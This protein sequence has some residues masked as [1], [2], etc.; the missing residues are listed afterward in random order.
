M[1]TGSG[2]CTTGPRQ[3]SISKRQQPAAPMGMCRQGDTAHTL[4][5]PHRS[6][7]CARQPQHRLQVAACHKCVQRAALAHSWRLQRG[8]N[9]SVTLREL[10]TRSLD[11]K[12]VVFDSA[13]KGSRAAGSEQESA[14]NQG[15]QSSETLPESSQQA[16]DVEGREADSVGVRLA[17]AALRFYKAEISPILPPSCRFFPTCSEYAMESF[18]KYGTGKGV[19]LTAWRLARCNPFGGRGY[20]PP[21]WPPPG[22][23]RFA[24]DSES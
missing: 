12:V 16:D 18:K 6:G 20:D 19:L 8:M 15:G 3:F 5:S 7:I 24:E 14:G 4:Q 11:R 22:F 17:L 21:T 23:E 10:G 13:S 1:L 2:K 9:G